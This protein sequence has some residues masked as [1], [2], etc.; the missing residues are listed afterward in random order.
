ME[1]LGLQG[2]A[3]LDFELFER[4]ASH[5]TPMEEY[6]RA[7]PLHKLLADALPDEDEDPMRLFARLTEGDI[8]SVTQGVAQGLE[9]LLRLHVRCARM[10]LADAASRTAAPSALSKFH[11]APLSCGRIQDF[12]AGLSGRIGEECQGASAPTRLSARSQGTQRTA[13][14]SSGRSRGPRGAESRSCR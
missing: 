4:V 9:R 11:V 12:H 10:A 5:P 13:H 3:H 1:N 8:A 14:G 6:V 7:V 2:H